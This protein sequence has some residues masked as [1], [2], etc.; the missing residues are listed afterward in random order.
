VNAGPVPVP[1]YNKQDLRPLL[2]AT[3]QLPAG[4]VAGETIDVVVDVALGEGVGCYA[5]EEVLPAGFQLAGSDNNASIDPANR[6]LKW[7]PFYDALPRT[8]R[9]RVLAPGDGKAN[10]EFIGNAS[11]DGRLFAIGGPSVLS[12]TSRFVWSLQFEPGRRA[13][14]LTGTPGWA[15]LIETSTDLKNW[16]ASVVV[17]N[18]T[19]SV[20]IPAA[21]RQD[22]QRFYQAKSLPSTN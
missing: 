18:A 11:A 15:Y 6:R 17:T 1:V 5:V 10:G 20:E 2:S 3:R 7:G 8:L 4:Y 13:L 16:N 9:Y 22:Q 21:V 19:G 12:P 14:R